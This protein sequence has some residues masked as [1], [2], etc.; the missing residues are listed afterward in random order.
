[1]AK[2]T[3]TLDSVAK[4]LITPKKESKFVGY[5]TPAIW[6]PPILFVGPTEL[7]VS[8]NSNVDFSALIESVGG[9]LRADIAKAMPSV[10]KDLSV[11]LYAAMRSSAWSWPG[12]GSRDIFDTGKLAASGK[13]IAQG[14][15]VSVSYSAPYA[16]IVHDGGYIFPYGNKKARPVYLPGRPWIASTIYGGGPVPQ[17]DFMASLNKNMR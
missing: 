8:I 1:M 17:F 11:A 15:G 2:T 16:S 12:G 6:V 10:A 7:G 5:L 4:R 13:V 3:I 14:S 9:D